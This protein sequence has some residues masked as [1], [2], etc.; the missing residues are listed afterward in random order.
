MKAV[1]A[2]KKNCAFAF[3]LKTSFKISNLSE[4]QQEVC[5]KTYEIY[6]KSAP[7]LFKYQVLVQLQS[8]A[9]ST[10]VWTE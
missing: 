1:E 4:K 5:T 10:P 7:V 3:L 2:E 6:D 9:H 8:S